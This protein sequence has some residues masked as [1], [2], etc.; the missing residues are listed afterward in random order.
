M[1]KLGAT[2][3]LCGQLTQSSLSD[4]ANI[5]DVYYSTTDHFT[6]QSVITGSTQPLTVTGTLMK[7]FYY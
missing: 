1:F 4:L 7:N 2:A 6:G 3:E 5:G